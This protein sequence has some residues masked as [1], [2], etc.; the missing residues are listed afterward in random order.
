LGK[1]QHKFV[2]KHWD[3]DIFTAAWASLDFDGDS[4]IKILFTPDDKGKINKMFVD[5][6]S[7]EGEGSFDKATEK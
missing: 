1:S 7:E 3:R 6:F 5:V 4:P 2:L